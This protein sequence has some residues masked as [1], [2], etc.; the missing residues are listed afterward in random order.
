MSE[1]TKIL[2]DLERRK[3]NIRGYIAD[4]HNRIIVSSEE[5]AREERNLLEVEAS[6][7]ALKSIQK[8]HC[9]D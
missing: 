5:K 1:L 6:L 3:Q 9:G 2:D 4:A 8:E 7:E